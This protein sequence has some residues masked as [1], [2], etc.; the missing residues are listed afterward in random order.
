MWNEIT[1]LF[2]NFNIDFICPFPKWAAA[3]LAAKRL[4]SISPAM[5][6]VEACLTIPDN[7]FHWAN[8]G[9]I[10]GRQDPAGPHVGPMNFAIWDVS[11]A[12]W[13]RSNS[14][15]MSSSRRPIKKY[16]PP[17][18][19][20]RQVLVN[21]THRCTLGEQS[22]ITIARKAAEWLANAADIF[23]PFCKEI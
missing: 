23:L 1:Y 13:V 5:T 7:K 21:P 19:N 15:F 22:L 8:M 14:T 4:P 12:G 11:P 3:N 17:K 6:P 10:W 2:P 18:N 16:E 9:P 20:T